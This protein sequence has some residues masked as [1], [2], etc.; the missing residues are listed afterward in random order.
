MQPLI[1]KFV[2]K[3]INYGVYSSMDYSYVKNRVLA[4]VGE[5]G[6]DT[7]TKEEDIKKLKD[8]LVEIAEKNEKVNTTV[9]EKDCLGAELMNFITP[10][11]SLM[12]EIFWNSYKVSP[13]KAIENF[14]QISKDNDYIKL[15]AISKNIAFQAETKY[16][17]LEITINLSKPEKD[18]KTIATE[19]LLKP[20]NY[21]KCLLCMENEGYQGRVNYPARANHR[22]IRMNLGEELWGF[23]YSPYSYFNEH[24]IFF[25]SEHVPMAITS[26]T[27]EQLLDII[28]I[29]PGYFVGSNSDLPISGGSILSHNHYQG[30]KYVFPMEKADYDI[31]FEFR[32]FED[33]EAGIVNWPM[34]VIRLRGKVDGKYEMDIVLRDNH[35]SEL[36]PDG[37]YH[38]HKD[39]HHIKKENIGLIEVMGL[40]ILP[41]RLKTE[42]EEVEKFLLNKPNEIANYHLDWAKQLKEK[43]SNIEEK[44]VTKIIQYEVGQVFARVLEDAGVYKNNQS[45][46]EGFKRFIEVVGIN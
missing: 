16:G 21:P 42:L 19:K 9:E 13:Q 23:Q 45:G 18:P 44:E 3:V 34:S 2:E 7:L 41:P 32:G 25:N 17:N 24:A 38:P 5:E 30:G 14:Y 11:P 12:N 36:H 1:D 39:V 27:F 20:S 33:I 8:S 31:N 10:I 28:D 22:I 15:S 6:I 46:R 40:A 29:I 4:L 43:Y 37:V 26:K 35:T